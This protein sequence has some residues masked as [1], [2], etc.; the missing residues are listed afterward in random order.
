ML[1]LDLIRDIF[2]LTST[3]GMLYVD[4]KFYCYV[5]EDT[6]RYLEKGGQKV[7]G[8]TAIPRGT[9][10]V[11]VDFSN[12]FQ[13]FLPLLLNVPQYAGVRIHTGNTALDTE[14]CLIV[15][16]LRSADKVSSSKMAFDGL[17]PKLKNSTETII[18]I[19]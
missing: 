14:G 1:R 2:T 15:G 8:K 4:G 18:C 3:T 12:H 5:L 13:K 19:S 17:L 7:F 10:R 6:D 11:I 16:M 9:Y